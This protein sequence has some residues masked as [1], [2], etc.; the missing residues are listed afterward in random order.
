MLS[1][2]TLHHTGHLLVLARRCYERIGAQTSE[3]Q[4]PIILAAVALEG[5]IND[6]EHHARTAS[7]LGSPSPPIASALARALATAEAER[8]SVLLKIGIAHVVMSGSFPD[9]GSQPYQDIELLFRLRNL[10]VHS[11]PEMVEF[12]EPGKTPDCPKIVRSLASRGV[13]K[14]PAA[15]ASV[16]WQ[17]YVVVPAVAAWAYNTAVRSMKWI[18]TIATED[19][20]RL[21]M[22]LQT[23]DLD[24]IETTQPAP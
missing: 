15:G 16:G 4:I 7:E 13:I 11:K 12:G 6:L 22:A 10:L 9:R 14:T 3:S 1:R 2:G 17:Q 24:E 18:A 20:L 5:F 8:A 23:K 19:W 21:F